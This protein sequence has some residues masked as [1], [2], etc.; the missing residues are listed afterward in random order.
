MKAYSLE[1]L[2]LYAIILCR[3]HNYCLRPDGYKQ[4]LRSLHAAKGDSLKRAG[5]E[6]R[7]LRLHQPKDVQN[8]SAGRA[9][10]SGLT[11]VSGLR[12]VIENCK[13][14][15][16]ATDMM[17]KHQSKLHAVGLRKTGQRIEDITAVTSYQSFFSKPFWRPFV[18]DNLPSPEQTSTNSPTIRPSAS[19]SRESIRS[20][21]PHENDSVSL[22]DH[23]AR[24]QQEWKSSFAS[25]GQSILAHESQTPPW[26]K[27]TG[28]AAFIRRVNITKEEIPKLIRPGEDGM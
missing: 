22:D 1:Y 19:A 10:I 2:P 16:S 25:F 6:I 26:L 28:I 15:T 5:E 24:S 11:I 7:T 8:P 9:P 13:F 18:V 27:S 20:P 4:H 21:H 12:C 14:I 23:Y 3:D 17:Q